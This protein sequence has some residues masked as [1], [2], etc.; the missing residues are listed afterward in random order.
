M[1]FTYAIESY[2]NGGY[3]YVK[4]KTGRSRLR[5][6]VRSITSRG[7]ATNMSLVLMYCNP[8]YDRTYAGSGVPDASVRLKMCPVR[9]NFLLIHEAYTTL[10]TA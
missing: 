1:L 7:A 6:T 9:L 3:D 8:G 10:A 2:P 5:E 4:G